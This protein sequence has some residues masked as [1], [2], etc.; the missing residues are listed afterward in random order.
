M[1]RQI[2]EVPTRAFRPAEVIFRE[3]DDPRAR[4]SWST[5]AGW[6]STSRSAAKT[7]CCA[8]S[9]RG[10]CLGELGLFGN[11]PRSDTDT[12]VAATAVTLMVV[13]QSQA[14]GVTRQFPRGDSCR[15]LGFLGGSSPVPHSHTV[16]ASSDTG[17]HS[18]VDDP[19]PVGPATSS[20]RILP[21]NRARAAPRTSG[22]DRAQVVP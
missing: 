12:A 13:I 15:L 7:G 5:L 3:G 8:C 21:P 14:A 16:R 4:P 9:P 18:G 20:R 6:K 11:A 1:S 17:E 2:G 19:R 10:S 22:G